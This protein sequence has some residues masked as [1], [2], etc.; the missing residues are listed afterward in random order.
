MEKTPPQAIRLLIL[1]PDPSALI[2]P[3]LLKSHGIQAE[4][5]TSVE[6]AKTLFYKSGFDAVLSEIVF[7][8]QVSAEC[9]S[10]L[11]SVNMTGVPVV[12]NSTFSYIQGKEHLQEL[13]SMGA[14]FFKKCEHPVA[15]VVK[16]IRDALVRRRLSS[17]V[18]S[19]RVPAVL[20]RVKPETLPRLRV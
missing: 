13:K 11:R 15:M 1:D 17:Y 20:L 9:V 4:I 8:N 12:V 5:A 19:F 7:S 2:Y 18:T 10:F 14:Y 6:Q 3:I 16:G